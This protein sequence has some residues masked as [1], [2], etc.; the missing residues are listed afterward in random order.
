MGWKNAKKFI[1]RR[2]RP[3][4]NPKTPK[5][6]TT[7]GLLSTMRGTSQ[8][9]NPKK[10]ALAR[11][12]KMCIQQTHRAK[13]SNK[14]KR[15]SWT[16]SRNRSYRQKQRSCTQATANSNSYLPKMRQKQKRNL[17]HRSR[18]RNSQLNSHIFQVHNMR[19]YPEGNRINPMPGRGL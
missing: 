6:G 12:S 14:T 10:G 18:R 19:T 16:P 3:E 5:D 1:K 11:L 15:A 2:K 8:N 9:S 7:G 4:Q 13:R 17:D